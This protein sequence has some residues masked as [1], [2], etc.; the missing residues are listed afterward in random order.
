MT[1]AELRSKF[2]EFASKTDSELDG[3][4]AEA[5]ALASTPALST[6]YAA[7]HLLAITSEQTG[8]PDGGS[9]EVR[10]ESLAGASMA[11]MPLAR[12]AEDVFWTTTPYGRRVLA[13]R[14]ASPR[15]VMPRAT[16]PWGRP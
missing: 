16:N 4:M 11:T 9:G 2:P 5:R 14:S 6:P 12:N 15:V 7:A 13:L 10:S 3:A 1:A 8:A